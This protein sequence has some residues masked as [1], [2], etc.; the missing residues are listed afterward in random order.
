MI[1]SNSGPVVL[2]LPLISSWRCCCCGGGFEAD[3]VLLAT[4]AVGDVGD[5]AAAT[6][7]ADDDDDDDDNDEEEGDELSVKSSINRCSTTQ[8]TLSVLIQTVG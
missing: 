2:S 6:A 3:L 8:E 5:V 4:A 7:A 1:Q